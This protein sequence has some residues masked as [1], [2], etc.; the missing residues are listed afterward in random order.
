MFF[1]SSG[2]RLDLTGLLAEPAALARVPLFLLAL[3][4]V[5]RRTGLLALR[6]TG[7]R[8][9]V[10]IGLLQATSLPFIVT[11]TQ[12][13]M[14]LDKISTVTSKGSALNGARARRLHGK[15]GDTVGEALR[16][17]AREGVVV[18]AVPRAAQPPSS[19]DPS[20]NGPP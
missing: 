5:A 20:R 14:T 12:I 4:V 9:A 13:G 2:V 16:R 7:P 11:A 3:P 19:I 17:P 8:G 10:A 1:V 15:H 6:M 18:A